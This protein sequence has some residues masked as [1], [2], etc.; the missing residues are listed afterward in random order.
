MKKSGISC[1]NY[2]KSTTALYFADIIKMILLS[3][4]SHTHT[5]CD[6]YNDNFYS[7]SDVVTKYIRNH[8]AWTYFFNERS[9]AGCSMKF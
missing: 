2:G 3:F 7:K 1:L 4:L 5:S 9:E 6:M 8:V